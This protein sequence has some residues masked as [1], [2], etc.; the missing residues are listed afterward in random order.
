MNKYT[1]ST[2]FDFALGLPPKDH[3][4]EKWNLSSIMRAKYKWFVIQKMFLIDS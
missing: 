2:G 4:N 3:W 1:N